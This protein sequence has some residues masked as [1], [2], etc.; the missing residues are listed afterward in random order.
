MKNLNYCQMR[1][2]EQKSFQE[3]LVFFWAWTLS[4]R[5][6]KCKF[7]NLMSFGSFTKFLESYGVVSLTNSAKGILMSIK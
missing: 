1:P 3:S 6:F 5:N 7:K 4:F 2:N